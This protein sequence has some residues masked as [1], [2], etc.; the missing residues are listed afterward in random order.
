MLRP[1]GMAEV[2]GEP[3]NVVTEGDFIHPGE[4]IEIV[5]V[6]GNR[7]VVKRAR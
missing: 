6:R 5:Q 3:L 4:P 1:A 7:I 2:D